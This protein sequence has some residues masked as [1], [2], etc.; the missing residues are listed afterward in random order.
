MS[1][2]ETE[3]QSLRE[4]QG[5]PPL[6]TPAER[7]AGVP[8]APHSAGALGSSAGKEEDEVSDAADREAA[9]RRQR[10]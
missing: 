8:L 3:T 9:E 4:E 6:E 7:I 5:K 2:D 10:E 1:D